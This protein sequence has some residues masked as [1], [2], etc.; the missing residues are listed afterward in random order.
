[1]KATAYFY[2]RG[3]S[4]YSRGIHWTRGIRQ[5][6]HLP[7]WARDAYIDGNVRQAPWKHILNG[8]VLHG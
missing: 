8:T 1:M 2:S 5:M 6:R 4:D 3:Q 7:Q